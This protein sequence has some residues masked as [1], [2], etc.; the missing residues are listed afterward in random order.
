RAPRES[1]LEREPRAGTGRSRG[2]SAPRDGWMP[3]VA[4]AVADV[5]DS[6]G[7]RLATGCYGAGFRSACGD[8]HGSTMR[9]RSGV[10]HVEIGCGRSSPRRNA[11]YRP[12]VW[13]QTAGD[14][15]T[16]SFTGANFWRGIIS[17]DIAQPGEY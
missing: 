3:P 15:S 2:G 14:W 6:A 11:H 8:R 4:E 17:E 13:A 7:I 5:A 1:T 9:R 10:A 12:H 16:G